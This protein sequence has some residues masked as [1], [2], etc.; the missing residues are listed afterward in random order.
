MTALCKVAQRLSVAFDFPVVFTS[1]VFVPENPV[2]VDTLDRLNEG[3]CHRALVY[4][5]KNVVL[6]QPSLLPQIDAYFAAHSS[7]MELADRP[8]TVPGGEPAKNNFGLVEAWIKQML[9]LHLD[10]HSFVLVVGGGAVLDAVGFAAAL[11]HR[12][13]RLV[14]LPTTVLAQND[15]GVGVKNGLNFNGGK[16]SIG[17]FAPPFAVINDFAFLRSLPL[18]D[19]RNG[20][21]EAFKVSVIRDASFLDYLVSH[22]AALRQRDEESMQHLVFR[23]AEL[24]LDHI[25]S[26]GD[27]FEFGS[28]RPL[29]FGHWSAHKIETMSGFATSHGDAVATGITLDAAYAVLHG[30]LAERDFTRIHHGLRESGFA[31]WSDELDRRDRDGKRT[32]FGGLQEFREHLGGQLSITFPNGV[33]NRVEVHEINLALMDQAIEKL[34]HLATETGRPA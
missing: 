17:T 26:N 13:L 33:G 32:V 20:I 28:A 24:H 30:W 16:N 3:K 10:R 5:D 31:L 12:G 11:V 7:R 23:C 9:D 6:H 27:P 8:Q 1:G 18:R 2:L 29:D 14:R 22:A 21:A 25:R 15:A 4:L 19:W 34:R